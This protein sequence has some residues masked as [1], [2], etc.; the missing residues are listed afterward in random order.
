MG[1]SVINLELAG[2]RLLSYIKN[3]D[4]FQSHLDCKGYSCHQRLLSTCHGTNHI[5]QWIEWWCTLPILK[6]GNTFINVHPYFSA[7]SRNMHLGLCTNGFN[8][9]E[10]FV[11]PY[12]CWPVILMVYNLPLEVC[13]RSEFMFLSTVIPGLNSPSRD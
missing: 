8:P 5:M 6:Y 10:S 9:I 4:T 12:S 2:E 7:K 13:M 3:L 11:A 1:I